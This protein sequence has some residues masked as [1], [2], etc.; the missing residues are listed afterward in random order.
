[1]DQTTGRF[2]CAAEVCIP[3]HTK[4]LGGRAGIILGDHGSGE[5][6][7]AIEFH[8]KGQLRFYWNGGEVDVYGTTDIRDGNWH[9]VEVV[10]TPEAITLRVDGKEEA[11]GK[12]GSGMTVCSQGTWV[13]HDWREGGM[14]FR[15]EIRRMEVN[16][17]ILV[18]PVSVCGN[19]GARQ[20]FRRQ[21]CA[22]LQCVGLY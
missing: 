16:G 11:T 22:S 7:L 1:M 20:T 6:G 10:R 19:C 13:G 9:T 21:T 14:A 2:E 18:D 8:A 17:V 15:G 12:G 5:K 4:H 3:T